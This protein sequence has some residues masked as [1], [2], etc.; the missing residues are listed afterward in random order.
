MRKRILFSL[1]GRFLDNRKTKHSF[2]TVVCLLFL[3]ENICAFISGTLLTSYANTKDTYKCK[4]IVFDN[5]KEL[6][7]FGRRVHALCRSK[8]SYQAVKCLGKMW[9]LVTDH[10][11]PAKLHTLFLVFIASVEILM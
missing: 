2:I 5:V 4:I 11:N 9:L 6:G 7:S 3:N 10:N 1:L 8:R